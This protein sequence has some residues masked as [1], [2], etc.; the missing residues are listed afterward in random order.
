MKTFSTIVRTLFLGVISVGAWSVAS[1]E[2]PSRNAEA[3][4]P[5]VLTP[6]EVKEKAVQVDTFIGQALR[7]QGRD[8]IGDSSDE[9]FLRRVYLSIIGRIPS[10][11]EAVAFLDSESPAK[12]AELIDQLLESPG[13]NSN[14]FNYWADILRAVHRPGENA[15]TNAISYLNYL[16]RSI[17]ENK[18]YDKWVSEMLTAS[19]GGWERKSQGAV[20]YLERDKGMPLDNMANTMQI[21]TGTRMEC[22]QCHN[23]PHN[24]EIEQKD[25]FYMAA[26]THGLKSPREYQGQG[27]MQERNLYDNAPQD[28]RNFVRQLRY[29]IFDFGVIGGGDGVVPLPMDYKYHDKDPGEIVGSKTIFGKRVGNSRAKPEEG[30]RMEF[31]E[32]LTSPD[33]PRFTKVISNRLWKRVMGLGLFEPVDEL[34]MEVTIS[35]PALLAHLE[36]SMVNLG[37][38]MKQFM[39][40]L[41]NTRTFQFKANPEEHSDRTY[42][43]AGRVLSRM[44]AEQIWDS[45]L[46]T[47]VPAID[48]RLGNH[49]LPYMQYRNSFVMV[50]QKPMTMYDLYE[51]TMALQ[52]KELY[53][54]VENLLKEMNKG[55]GSMG[56][57]EMM[58][59]A[60]SESGAAGAGVKADPRWTSYS[61]ELLRASELPSPAPANHFLRKFGQSAREVIE[62][63][64]T[65][66]DV[67]Q[68]LSLI[69]G[70][71]ESNIIGNGSAVIYQNMEKAATPEEKIEVAF[72]STLTRR[73][74]SEEMEIFKNNVEAVGER[75]YD[76]LVWTLFNTNEFIF[77][78]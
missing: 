16:K 29:D 55:G 33:N 28:V 25:F 43:F 78:Q 15:S 26:F 53:D 12:R 9:Q 23:H 49:F 32:W 35:H 56:G 8:L 77:V 70:H 66:S 68:I 46:S 62:G 21:F 65:E 18:P 61:G 5:R 13:Y 34:D 52:G 48:E 50:D 7:E 2:L 63:Q 44:S 67:T 58:E 36:K 64:T 60:M 37:Y 40:V 71:V 6:E 57:E 39:R 38:D 72:L 30:S 45:M 19:G 74:T 4:G 69:N 17:A 3:S 1:A 75:G 22:A 54:Y 24:E 14:M 41:Y 47:T 27:N 51:E 73:P 10:Y 76:D 59:M 31:A 42:H 11:E 20:G